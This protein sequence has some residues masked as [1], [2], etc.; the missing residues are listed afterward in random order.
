MDIKIVIA[1]E[2][3]QL[4]DCLNIRHQ[5]FVVEQ[6]IPTEIEMDEH[7]K[8]STHFLIYANEKPIAT[9]RYRINNNF[10]KFERIATIKSMRGK[11]IGTLLMQKMQKTGLEKYPAYLQVTNS[12]KNSIPFYK[13]L[14]WVPTGK[15]FIEAKIE[16][17][18]MI[19]LPKDIKKLKCLDDPN[20]PSDI[21]KYLRYF[22]K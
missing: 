7:E 4:R 22:S 21:L 12:Q 6:N 19:F 11:K 14:G 3:S 2:E 13:K 10:L 20:C 18:L 1:N 17:Q 5:V 15:I 16:H 9:G 8:I